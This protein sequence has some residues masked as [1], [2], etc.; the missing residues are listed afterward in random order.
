VP[1]LPVPFILIMAFADGDTRAEARALGA[2]AFLEKPLSITDLQ[3]AI[4]TAI[5]PH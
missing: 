4:R 3:A 5:E 1:A 2:A